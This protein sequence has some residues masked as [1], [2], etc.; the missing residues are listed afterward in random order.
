MDTLQAT[1]LVK[2]YGKKQVLKGLNLTLESGKIY[3][4]IGRNGVGKTTLL[5]ILTGQNKATSGSA[6]LNGKPV[7]ENREALSQ[8]CFSRELSSTL[9]GGP[10]QFKVKHYLDA[11]SL[12][13][14]TW[15][16]AYAQS[17]LTL[18]QL[19][20]KKK[21]SQ[22]SKGQTSLVTIVIALASG[23]PFTILD[24]PVAGLDVVARDDFYRLLLEN[25]QKTSRTFVISTHIIEEAAN[26]F[27]EVVFLKDGVVLEKSTTDDLVCQFHY[28]SGHEEAVD[29][30]C[31]N[32][33]IL[34]T[35]T[36]GRRKTCAVRGKI[37]ATAD[38][39]VTPMN[40]QSVFLTLCGGQREEGDLC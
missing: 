17:L 37:L 4:L 7:W 10:N 24:E 8:I 15:D 38:V 13:Y 22:L 39:D 6:T 18:F 5:G 35:Q 33:D 16:K 40:L 11:A 3:G 26:V 1:D 14:K 9:V 25:Y 29:M 19:N 2:N 21:I 27:E 12:F 30:A 34:S 36:M 28:V 31:Q 23:C 20:P 32:L